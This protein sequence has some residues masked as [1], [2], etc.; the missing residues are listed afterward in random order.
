MKRL[1]KLKR[2]QGYKSCPHLDPL[3]M[4]EEILGAS[5]YRF[6]AL[7]IQRCNSC[8]LVTLVTMTK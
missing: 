4:G 8:N 3:P 7:T 6:N 5:A 2:V 1:K